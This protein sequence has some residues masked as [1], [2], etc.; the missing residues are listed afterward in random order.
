VDFGA[1]G[2]QKNL[3]RQDM[4]EAKFC[5]YM[6]KGSS[7]QPSRKGNVAAT[8]FGGGV[9]GII[10]DF[11]DWLSFFVALLIGC[12]FLESHGV[13][14]VHTETLHNSAPISSFHVGI[15]HTCPLL[16]YSMRILFP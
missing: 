6:V 3:P 4:G 10:L 16:P 14:F 8:W 11:P 7:G 9:Y 13:N 12:F 1:T 2:W 5:S 15:W